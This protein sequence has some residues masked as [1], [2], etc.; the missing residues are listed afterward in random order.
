M[1]LSPELTSRVAELLGR[2]PRGLEDIS[3][4]GPAGEPVVIR[5]A[6]L[7]EDKPFPTL[8]WLVDPDISYRIDRE[9][10]TGLIAQLQSRIDTEPALQ[11]AMSS[12][13]KAHIRLRDSFM[14][15]AV[16]LRL[17]QLGYADVLEKKGIGGIADFSRIRCL[18]TWYAAHRVVPNTVGALLDEHWESAG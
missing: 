13:H 2:E 11:Q 17:V 15:S 10:A 9:E 7:V 1:R 4:S 14:S 3:V 5:V 16:R 12:D 18:H 6:S 8:F